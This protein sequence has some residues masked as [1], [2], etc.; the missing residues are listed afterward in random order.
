MLEEGR[1]AGSSPNGVPAQLVPTTD[2]AHIKAARAMIVLADL[3][4][5]PRF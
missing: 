3:I 5:A 1:D 2:I 4:Q